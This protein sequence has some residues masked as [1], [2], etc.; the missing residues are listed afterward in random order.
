MSLHTYRIALSLIVLAALG[1][2]L[3]VI[4][5]FVGLGAP[6]AHEDG[7][8][9]LDYELLAWRLADGRGYTLED[10]Q[11][12]ARRTPGTP[13][14]LAPVYA[15]CGRS[16]LAARLWFA[17]L[18]AA[19]CAVA[20]W[21]VERSCGRG[22]ALVAAALLAVNPGAFY[23][24][25]HIWSE[26]PYGFF[27]ALGTLLSIEAW[28]REGRGVGLAALAGACW[29]VALL[30]RP[31]V[32]FCLPLVVLSLWWLP[33]A[34]RWR[35]VRQLAVQGAVVAAM[36]LPWVVR[37]AVVMGKPCL[38]TVVGPMTFW[39]AHNEVSLTDPQWR[40]RWDIPDHLVSDELRQADEITKGEMATD[41]AWASLRTH[42]DQIPILLAA[43][44]YW[45]VTPFE[46][47]TNRGVYWS[48]ALAW[49]V[50]GPLFVIGLR[51]LVRR[52]PALA[53]QIL[54]HAGGVVLGTL[55]FYGAARFRHAI[56][57]L[58]MASAA[59]GLVWC[60]ERFRQITAAAL[61]RVGTRHR[62]SV[63]SAGR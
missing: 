40:G 42:A 18:S 49:I 54:C 31:Q 2:R 22:T 48:F 41:Q 14:L 35:A 63:P 15:L 25:L 43:K 10:G 3:T 39:G 26:A 47:T 37:N 29:G 7:L 19:T 45:L 21:L 5:R 17:V 53:V 52:D 57:P 44:L 46:P 24:T 51:E 16:P 59:V 56:E 4:E 8:D 11:P 62:T 28:R 9:Q 6:I 32:V 58:L 60:L 33:L 34:A 13:L 50:T 30:I 38:A 61:A 1:V 27:V 20:A 23:Y 36:V 55:L 12:T